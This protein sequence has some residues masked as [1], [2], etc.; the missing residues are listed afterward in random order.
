M[1]SIL[2]WKLLRGSATLLILTV[3]APAAHTQSMVTWSCSTSFT[4]GT[5]RIFAQQTINNS[6]K[7]LWGDGENITL[8]GGAVFNNLADGVFE[9]TNNGSMVY[10]EGSAFNNYGLFKQTVGGGTTFIGKFTNYGTVSLQSGTLSFAYDYNQMAGAT[11]LAGGELNAW[12]NSISILGGSLQGQGTVEAGNWN[13][14]VFNNGT[15]SPTGLLKIKDAS[16]AQAS[17][18]SLNITLG[19]TNA[20][21]SYGQLSVARGA[22]LAGALNITLT[23]DFHPR[24]GQSFQVLTCRSCSGRFAS[25]NAPS[26]GDGLALQPTYTAT[27]LTLTVVEG[28]PE[29]PGKQAVAMSDSTFDGAVLA[30]RR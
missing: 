9:V 10:D 27:S 30:S 22:K 8:S 14:G 4:N 1:K 3:L 21:R 28:R 23:N 18:G 6:G 13:P 2:T 11:I 5:G 15:I 16:Y 12:P 7:V 25:I 20:G 19:G 26:L 24:L 17:S 29:A